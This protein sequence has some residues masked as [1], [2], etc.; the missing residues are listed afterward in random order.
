M[1]KPTPT[2]N[3]SLTQLDEA[4][5]ASAGHLNHANL[6]Y[7]HSVYQYFERRYQLPGYSLHWEPGEMPSEQQWQQLNAMLKGHKDSYL[8]WEDEP[9]PSIKHR[10]DSVG[11]KY[12]VIKPAANRT[13]TNWRNEQQANLKRIHSTIKSRSTLH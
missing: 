2:D 3:L 11:L 1:G 13:N 6:I 7:S 10:L 12:L 5:M 9:A 8:I 4:Y